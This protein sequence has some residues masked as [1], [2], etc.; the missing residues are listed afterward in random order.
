MTFRFLDISE[1]DEQEFKTQLR[2]AYN[3]HFKN[4]KPFDDVFTDWNIPEL[5]IQNDL[6]FNDIENA[7]TEMYESKNNGDEPYMKDF[8]SDL[9]ENLSFVPTIKVI[10]DIEY[11]PV[12]SFTVEEMKQIKEWKKN[13][14]I[15]NHPEGE[16]YQGAVGVERFSYTLLGTS[17]GMIR[18]CF[19]E[20][21]R[22]KYEEESKDYTT[23]SM[24]VF[25]RKEKP[26]YSEEERCKKLDELRKKWDY[27]IDFSD[28]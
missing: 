14:R 28:W 5:S 2:I 11:D 12:H 18:N 16:T 26:K 25:P 19:C 3:S 21:C 20:S 7:K 8:I 1:N 23:T 17:I 13:H 27:Q 24:E 9:Q 10:N 4:T 6:Y 15:K 22:E